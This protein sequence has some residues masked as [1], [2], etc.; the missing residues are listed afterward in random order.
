[1]RAQGGIH[2]KAQCGLG[3]AQDRQIRELYA[4]KFG[5]TSVCQA[6][7][8]DI[9]SHSTGAPLQAPLSPSP[10]RNAPSGPL[11]PLLFPG[12]KGEAISRSA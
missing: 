9:P 11:V 1:M 4:R 8:N 12:V 3:T 2:Q 6:N 7:I 10:G 5:D